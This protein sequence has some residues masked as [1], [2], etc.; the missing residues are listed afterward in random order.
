MVPI[1]IFFGM[2]SYTFF[3]MNLHFFKD[4]R[5]FELQMLLFLLFFL[6]YSAGEGRMKRNVRR[7][8]GE[9]RENVF[10]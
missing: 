9:K 8:R 2:N 4:L 10:F 7:I 3:G 1:L 5:G 6:E